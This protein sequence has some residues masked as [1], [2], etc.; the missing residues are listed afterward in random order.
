MEEIVFAAFPFA[1]RFFECRFVFGLHGPGKSAF[2]HVAEGTDVVV[3]NP[4]PKGELLFVYNGLFIQHFHNL[5]HFHAF[6]LVVVHTKH[7]PCVDFVLSEGYNNSTASQISCG[8]EGGWDEISE[9]VE[10]D[11]KDDVC[12]HDAFG[13]RPHRIIRNLLMC[14]EQ[15]G[16]RNLMG[17]V[18]EF[19][20]D[21]LIANAENSGFCCVANADVVVV[22]YAEVAEDGDA[23]ADVP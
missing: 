20:L 12:K 7:Y 23:C 18:L 14:L 16:Q 3:G 11:R 5:F 8:L 4:L 22:A 13:M 17:V 15:V 19:A 1:R 10:R 9:A 2:H 21:G 6:G